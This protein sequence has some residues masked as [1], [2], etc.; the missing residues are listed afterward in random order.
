MLPR[1]LILGKRHAGQHASRL[2]TW[3]AVPLI[4]TLAYPALAE[5]SRRSAPRPGAIPLIFRFDDCSAKSDT[6]L[7]KAILEAFQRT[8]TP[9]TVSVVPR[10]ASV[11]AFDPAPQ[12]GVPLPEE[13]IRLL[14]EALDAGGVEVALH[15]FSHQTVR[16]KIGNAYLQPFGRYHSEFIGVDEASQRKKIREG[17]EILEREL[18]IRAETFVPP[19]NGYDRTTLKVLQDSGFTTLSA[20]RR[21]PVDLDS[22]LHFLPR[23]CDL[24]DVQGAVRAA[25]E[26]LADHPLV[27]VLFHHY[28]FEENDPQAGRLSLPDL[29]RTLGWVAAQTDL[30][31]MTLRDASR[32]LPDL[33]ARQFYWNRNAL[34]WQITPP[35][36]N[37]TIHWPPR[38]VYQSL[39]AARRAKLFLW[40]VV[41]L[42]YGSLAFAGTA[43]SRF[44]SKRL[45]RGR[46]LLAWSVR[47]ICVVALLAL[48]LYVFWDLEPYWAGVAAISWMAGFCAGLL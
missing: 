10:V 4:G 8:H 6:A 41:L 7:E 31:L 27:V 46:P 18:G 1:S 38:G 14:R 43:I 42:L 15:G 48:L 12:A 16:R 29:N 47:I 33:G 23:T 44:A 20:A 36:V 26:S 5:T 19:W 35:W 9:L 2:L 13:K 30:R 21:G 17:R 37:L 32:L 22:S 24:Q 3:A 34:L 25:R 45:L 11:S 39:P 28:D 40:C